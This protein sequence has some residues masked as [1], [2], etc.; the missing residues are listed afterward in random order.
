MQ[1]ATIVIFA[2]LTFVLTSGCGK[3]EKEECE[4]KGTGWYWDESDKECKEKTP[5]GTKGDAAG[6]AANTGTTASTQIAETEAQESC[7]SKSGYV[8][9]T[10]NS[11]CKRINYF[12]LIRPSKSEV[13]GVYMILIGEEYGYKNTFLKQEND[14]VKVHEPELPKLKVK[15]QWSQYGMLYNDICSYPDAKNRSHLPQPPLCELGVY[16]I[17]V[18]DDGD[19]NLQAVTLDEERTDCLPLN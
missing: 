4:D 14:C 12:M 8:W 15:A 19:M 18:N 10:E 7:K 5:G 9:N 13:F 11:Q 6:G 1:K 2:F 3:S 16:T 17:S